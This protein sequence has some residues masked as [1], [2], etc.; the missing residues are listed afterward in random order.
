MPRPAPA[1]HP[2]DPGVQADAHAAARTGG[3]A[4][5]TR[6]CSGSTAP[7]G[8]P[9]RPQDDYLEMLDE[10]ERRDHRK[11]G[12]E[13]DLFS[14]P[15]EIGSRPG[16]LPPQGR[17]HPP[18]DGGLLAAA[19]RGGGLRV[20]QHPAHHQGRAVRDLRPPAVVRREHVPADGARGRRVLPQADELPDAQPD[21]PVAR[22]VLPRAA[23]AA[24]RVRHR[25]PVREVRRGARPDP[26][27]RPDHGRLAHLLHPRADGRR[28][29]APAVASCST[30]CATTG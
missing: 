9:A 30:C 1:D 23:A 15:D 11:L 20:R 21:L 24:V 2:A 4:R 6:S 22:A 29:Q 7:P 10:A 13:L 3:A 12:A 5:R 27:P 28:A 8:S 18:G 25:V 14:F 16:G 26:G 17:H 19:A